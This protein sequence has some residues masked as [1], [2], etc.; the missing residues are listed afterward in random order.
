MVVAPA[1]V[2]VVVEVVHPPT[3]AVVGTVSPP[4][5]V[6]VVVAEQA[7]WP[8]VSNDPLVTT[9]TSRPTANNAPTAD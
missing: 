7:S 9:D 8:A 6:E 1:T 5:I 3:C 4:V 2:V